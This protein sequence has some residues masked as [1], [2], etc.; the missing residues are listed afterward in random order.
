MHD[1]ISNS[2]ASIPLE[3]TTPKCLSGR[4]RECQATAREQ[5]SGSG[6]S[7]TEI[8]TAPY[9]SGYLVGV[10]H[11]SS[12]LFPGYVE[13]T[14]H[15]GCEESRLQSL[16]VICLCVTGLMSSHRPP[17]IT[18]RGMIR[19]KS[20][21]IKVPVVLDTGAGFTYLSAPEHWIRANLEV[22]PISERVEL[23]DGTLS[24]IKA[25]I[26]TDLIVY[27]HQSNVPLQS[28]R[29]S[30]TLRV[31]GGSQRRVL[32]GRDLLSKWMLTIVGASSVFTPSG[33]CLFDGAG[34]R[35]ELR[36]VVCSLTDFSATTVPTSD[37]L[38]E[39][40]LAQLVSVGWVPLP[41]AGNYEGRVRPIQAA[42]RL[43][44]PG[45]SHI[46]EVRFPVISEKQPMRLPNYAAALFDRLDDEDKVHFAALVDGYVEKGLWKRGNADDGSLP[47]S[48]VFM[49]RSAS[50]KRRLVVDAR[51]VNSVLEHASSK[52]SKILN[53]L[54]LMRCFKLAAVGIRDLCSAFY[55]VRLHNSTINLDTPIGRYST[56]R[57][58]FGLAV[59]PSGLSGVV[60]PVIQEFKNLLVR[61]VDLRGVIV[62]QHFVDDI[63]VAVSDA[64]LLRHVDRLFTVFHRVGFA[65]QP[66]KVQELVNVHDRGTLF[67]VG[68]DRVIDGFRFSCSREER[69]LESISIA[70]EALRS[71]AVTKAEI[72]RLSGC[73]G[74]DAMGLHVRHRFCADLLR[75]L[76]GRWGDG[77]R[78]QRAVRDLGPAGL[79]L[80]REVA[81]ATASACEHKSTPIS[82]AEC[83]LRIH[84]DASTYGYGYQIEVKGSGGWETIVESAG[85]WKPPQRAHHSNLKELRCVFQ[86]LSATADIVEQARRTSVGKPLMFY[87]SLLCDNAS[88]VS[89]VQD[90]QAF[91]GRALEKRSIE[92][93]L[94]ACAAAVR[95][96]RKSG[97]FNIAHIPGESNLTADGLSRFGEELVD[98]QKLALWVYPDQP[99]PSSLKQALDERLGDD[100]SDA[101]VD[102]ASAMH[103]T[104]GGD[105]VQDSACAVL[106]IVEAHSHLIDQIATYYSDPDSIILAFSRVRFAFRFWASVVNDSGGLSLP[107]W[108][109]VPDV[110]AFAECLQQG[111]NL[112]EQPGKDIFKVGQVFIHRR[113]LFGGGEVDEIVVPEFP[114]FRRVLVD[115]AHRRA[116]HRGPDSTFQFV[117]GWYFQGC[118]RMCRFHH[119]FCVV[120]RRSLARQTASVGRCPA[121]R[122]IAA[123]PYSVCSVDYITLGE[124]CWVLT[125]YC[126]NSL[127]VSFIA[128]DRQTAAAAAIALRRLV[129]RLNLR[130]SRVHSDNSS[131][132]G[133][134]FAQ[135]L[136]K[137]LGYFVEVTHT[138]PY[139]SYQNPAERM[140]EELLRM[141]RIRLR[142]LP[143]AAYLE[144]D[145][146]ERQTFLDCI[147]AILNSRPLGT[148]DRVG[149]GVGEGVEFVYA[150]PQLLA[151]GHSPTTAVKEDIHRVRERFADAI[152]ARLKGRCDGD[153]G[154]RG[155][156]WSPLV[157]ERV[158][159]R[160]PAKKAQLEWCVA[161]VIDR[162]NSSIIVKATGK[163]RRVGL[164]DV[165]QCPLRE[166]VTH[167]RFDVTRVGA[168]ITVDVGGME[169]FG[170]VVSEGG[171]AHQ[172]RVR[173]AWQ[174]CDNR[175]WW[176]ELVDWGACRV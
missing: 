71:G 18:L 122:D 22:T 166:F 55:H 66:S 137:R 112:E 117:H 6:T 46:Y 47:S 115:D 1:H 3:S 44:L 78:R 103:V 54:S 48:Q 8:P 170:T 76:A 139:A 52:E 21:W 23:A 105:T 41:A 90:P 111:A 134:I 95:S 49:V 60:S 7:L 160:I 75:S 97:S 29:C 73:L 171:A 99:L 147:S 80:L 168:K 102:G 4:S 159:V 67:G 38:V 33:E 64:E 100:E 85:I 81:T 25:Q 32:A 133:D 28:T 154:R 19:G 72:F 129:V 11:A 16:D 50:G 146:L 127:H 43:D 2:F 162:I 59:G 175:R 91:K 155:S 101:T 118:R 61:S 77:W 36:D 116:G 63:T 167:T 30:T 92:Y 148:L 125:V 123:A 157:G 106:E 119:R 57:L 104:G 31:I 15:Q 37:S 94:N 87:V 158:L 13:H 172:S 65:T 114:R 145:P 161:E 79:Y 70:T 56:D 128:C 45:Q 62:I 131:V 40:C 152:W 136:H 34:S 109:V 151:F 140:N 141:A 124:G 138:S 69:L 10:T 20:S 164:Y 58:A 108:P 107:V 120:C 53:C 5:L 26:A 88:T 135:E 89:W 17:A 96:I 83:W 12:D 153:H 110:P 149:G 173:I 42:D 163:E 113:H 126:A 169:Y 35:C 93:L 68:V 132:F 174:P 150:C 14:E 86:A 130:L 39:S 27:S 98:G 9:R 176:D 144:K 143:A 121:P 142:S 24:D 156:R 165:A 51:A 74:Y 84:T 82:P